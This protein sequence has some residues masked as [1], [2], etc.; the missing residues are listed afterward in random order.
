MVSFLYRMPNGI[1]GDVSR[2]SQS[3]IEAQLKN[4]ALPFTRYGIP[5]KIAGG[6]F[7]PLAGGEVGTAVY[8]FLVRPF[9]TQ[10]ANASDP[11]G[12]AVPLGDSGAA[13]V[14]RRGYMTVKLNAGVAALG[15][16]VFVRV[17]DGTV[18]QP[19]GGI[20]AAADAGDCV[21]IPGCSFMGAADASGNVEI[22][23]NI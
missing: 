3:T 12:T 20:E 21:A 13:D 9:P 15:G 5:G 19:I 6:K 22:A 7:V 1:P 8:G 4:G 10:G 18:N 14:M 2:P 17:A 16:A 23:F 11:L